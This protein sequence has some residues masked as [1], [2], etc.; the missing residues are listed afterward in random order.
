MHPS[1]TPQANSCHF[2]VQCAYFASGP[3]RYRQ[4][5]PHTVMHTCAKLLHRAKQQEAAAKLE[6]AE[7]EETKRAMFW[8][9]VKRNVESTQLV[10]SPTLCGQ[11]IKSCWTL[12]AWLANLNQP[13]MRTREEDMSWLISCLR[14][15]MASRP[16]LRLHLPVSSASYFATYVLF[17][18]SRHASD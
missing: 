12:P 4:T 5:K 14:H 11:C 2:M 16:W 17:A 6:E 8:G 13:F 10:Q 1:K 3:L 7:D 15:I 9:R 18:I